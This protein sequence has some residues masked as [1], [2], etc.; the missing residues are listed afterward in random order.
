MNNLFVG[1]F[2]ISLLTFSYFS[3]L[4]PFSEPEPPHFLRLRLRANCFSGSGSGSG[5]ASLLESETILMIFYSAPAR[6]LSAVARKC[7]TVA[8]VLRQPSPVSV[9]T[10]STRNTAAVS[11][12]HDRTPRPAPLS[13]RH[14][15][16]SR[17]QLTRSYPTH[18][19]RRLRLTGM[20]T[21]DMRCAVLG[22]P[23][24]PPR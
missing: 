7:V 2:V 20:M 22:T 3:Q 10:S 6:I 5:S 19:D 17:T 23:D 11:T 9:N 13:P 1:L 24:F 18:R 21:M 14:P 4:Y 8:D 15:H 16:T 12:T